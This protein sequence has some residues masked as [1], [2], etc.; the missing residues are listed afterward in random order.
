MKHREKIIQKK[1]DLLKKI[2]EAIFGP[3]IIRL[4][5]KTSKKKL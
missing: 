3:I 2:L 5:N 1:D 4:K